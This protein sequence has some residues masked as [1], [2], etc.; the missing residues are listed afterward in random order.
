MAPGMA[1]PVTINTPDVINDI[2]PISCL[3]LPLNK[4]PYPDFEF[5]DCNN[6]LPQP[7]RSC[8]Y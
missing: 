2:V 5:P 3:K 7:C 8:Q 6:I 1:K 4:V